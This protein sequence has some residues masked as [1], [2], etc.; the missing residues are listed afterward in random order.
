MKPYKRGD[1]REKRKGRS[2]FLI[3]VRKEGEKKKGGEGEAELRF[4]WRG[5]GESNKGSPFP[6]SPLPFVS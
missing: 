2:K 3:T 1:Q 5:K 4:C 6:L